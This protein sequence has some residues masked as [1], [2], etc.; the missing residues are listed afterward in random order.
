VR[1]YL[2]S[3]GVLI[4]LHEFGA[5]TVHN[6]QQQQR[7]HHARM[8]TDALKPP[9]TTVTSTLISSR[10]SVSS[11]S[12]LSSA[13]RSLAVSSSCFTWCALDWSVALSCSSMAVW[14]C[15][16]VGGGWGG[17]GVGGEGHRGS[18]NGLRWEKRGG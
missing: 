17:W 18:G 16:G 8:H 9:L 12:A 15:V 3:S 13:S 4:R 2:D 6:P 14:R 1:G 11:G 10:G 5:S 7:L